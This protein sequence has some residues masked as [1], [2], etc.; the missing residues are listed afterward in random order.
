[1]EW[2]YSSTVLDLSNIHRRV[3]SFTHLPFYPR[4][5]VDMKSRDG[6]V[7]IATGYRLDDREVGVRVPVGSKIFSS[8]RRPERF[9]GPS[10]LLSNGYRGW[11]PEPA[12][13]LWRKTSC[14][15]QKPKPARTV[16]SLSLYRLGYPGSTTKEVKDAKVNVK[17]SLSLNTRLWR[18]MAEWR[19]SLRI[20]LSTW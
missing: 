3:V 16:C 17:M 15:W 18:R 11:A 1:V 6:V 9:W 2:R 20:N 12:W 5:P 13:T 8:P 10:S 14:P 7:G 19:Y 4:Y